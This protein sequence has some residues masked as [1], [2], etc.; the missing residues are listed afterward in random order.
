MGE[1]LTIKL[2]ASEP[3]G[4]RHTNDLDSFSCSVQFCGTVH[5]IPCRS[6][7]ISCP[8]RSAAICS[9]VGWPC[10]AVPP[11][12]LS[13]PDGPSFLNRPDRLQSERAKP[14]SSTSRIFFMRQTSILKTHRKSILWSC[15]K[16]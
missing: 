6:H 5:D 12:A 10:S 8:P 7:F 4:E 9:A 14:I 2:A 13:E 15:L 16:H 1:M 11:P 3:P